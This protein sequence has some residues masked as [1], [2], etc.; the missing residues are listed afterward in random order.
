L[1]AM[2]ARRAR[3]RL[4]AGAGAPSSSGN[5]DALAVKTAILLKPCNELAAK[6]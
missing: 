6:I 3:Q 5:A 4:K 1:P 2:P